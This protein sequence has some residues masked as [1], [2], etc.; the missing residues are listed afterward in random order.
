MLVAMTEID[1]GQQI[2]PAIQQKIADLTGCP[3]PGQA[4][5]DLFPD[6]LVN[7]ALTALEKHHGVGIRLGTNVE[8]GILAGFSDDSIQHI[9][10]ADQTDFPDNAFC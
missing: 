6:M 5:F 8:A 3:G 10:R 4:V 7:F 9:D 2:R 1:P